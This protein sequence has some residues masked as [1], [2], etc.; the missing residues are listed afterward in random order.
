MYFDPTF[1]YHARKTR[2]TKDYRNNLEWLCAPNPVIL[3]S[4]H[5]LAF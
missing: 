5:L 1:V 4:F 2:Y 3:L